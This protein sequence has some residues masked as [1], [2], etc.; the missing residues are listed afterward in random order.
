MKVE[1]RTIVAIAAVLAGWG[2]MAALFTPQHWVLTRRAPN[3]PHWSELFLGNL[4]MFWTW[5][6]LTP[7]IV[8]LGRRFPLERP[9]LPLHLLL[10]FAGGF[11]F[12][13]AHIGILRYAN[14]LLTGRPVQT[15]FNY[16]ISYGATGVLIAIVGV[17]G[18]FRVIAVLQTRLVGDS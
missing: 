10:H 11:A 18:L 16:V 12:T 13:L 14:A 9:R 3:A 15:W 5:A 8:W 2:L 7:A 6:A 1:R 4:V 17:V